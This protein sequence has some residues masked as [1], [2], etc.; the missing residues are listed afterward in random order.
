MTCFLSKCFK[1]CWLT[2]LHSLMRRKCFWTEF[3]INKEKF[4]FF[5]LILYDWPASWTKLGRNHFFFLLHLVTIIRLESLNK[6]RQSLDKLLFPSPQSVEKSYCRKLH[7][8]FYV[9]SFSAE[10]LQE[11]EAYVVS[12]F[13]PI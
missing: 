12:Y 2:D 4:P 11:L 6:T 1:I 7:R 3:D 13:S 5:P 8:Y 10:I 9:H